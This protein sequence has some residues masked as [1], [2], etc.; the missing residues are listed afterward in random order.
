M[1]SSWPER[2]EQMLSAHLPE[3]ADADRRWDPADVL[4]D[5]GIDSLAVVGLMMDVEDEFGFVFPDD[6]VT[7]E[8][9][10]T[11]GSLWGVVAEQ[12]TA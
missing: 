1:M 10:R 2:F 9:F 8:T 12:I 11:A 5:H 7:M 6:K 4:R 3:D